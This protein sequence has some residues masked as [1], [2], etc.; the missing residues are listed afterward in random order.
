MQTLPQ[1]DQALRPP[2]GIRTRSM[3]AMRRVVQGTIEQGG[4]GLTKCPSCGRRLSELREVGA[5][6]KRVC[7]HCGRQV[8]SSKAARPIC[9]KCG[10]AAL[11]VLTPKEHPGKLFF[12][13]HSGDREASGCLVDD[14]G[15]K[16][17]P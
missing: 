9:P 11:Y 1:D 16:E 10:L 15:F 17:T 2:M 14:P 4:S 12:V 8:H 3:R 6:P 13:H 7:R 5:K